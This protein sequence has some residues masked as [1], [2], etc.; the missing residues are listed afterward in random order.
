MC[1]RL[2]LETVAAARRR[3]TGSAATGRR[4]TRR[5]RVSSPRS[6]RA[7][8]R[9][10]P[11]WASPTSRAIAARGSSTRSGLDRLLCRDVPRR[12]AVRDRRRAASSASSGRRS[13]DCD[14]S[15]EARPRL[16]NPGY[17]KF[18][19][20]GEPHATDPDVVDALQ[21]AVAG[22]HA[23][24]TAV[25]ERPLRPL[26]PLRRARERARARSSRATCSSSSRS[27]DPVPLDEVEPAD[28]IVR[29]FSGGA[30]SHGALSSEAHETIAIALNSLGA[31]ANS[32]EGGENP[33]R[34]R[35]ERNSQDQAGRVR[36]L[37]R[38][39]RVRG[40]RGGAPDQDRA[41]LEAR[42]G[43]PDPGAQGDRG[44]RAA[45]ARRGPASRS[46]RRRRTTTSTRSRISRSS[47]STCAR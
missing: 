23:L 41:G 39:R 14:A 47:S 16:E 2:A 22:A 24:R 29:R 6:R 40:V 10:C 32:G 11:R 35:D 18:R 37:R 28:E 17:F 21:E 15:G 33:E 43:R 46:S 12:H 19:K 26:R 9:S 13:S 1:P 45:C 44:D 36:P 42:R 25:R 27:G 20:G 38:D 4:R 8:S 7:C 31:R 3:T 5:K 34:Y 30:M